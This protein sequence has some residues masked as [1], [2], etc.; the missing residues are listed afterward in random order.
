MKT[1]HIDLRKYKSAKQLVIKW[2]RHVHPKMSLKKLL[3]ID[4]ELTISY[5]GK[6]F[7]PATAKEF[8][9][10]LTKKQKIWA[11]C[12]HKC[13]CTKIIHIWYKKDIDYGI[14]LETI[15]HEL[16]H[17]TGTHNEKRCIKTGGLARYASML[18]KDD[19]KF[20]IV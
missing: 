5:D 8:I 2:C 17:A 7:K 1:Y 13:D 18:I 3:D 16:E 15:S 12:E 4:M 19:L 14:L 10:F 20:K 11:F 9:K 6:K